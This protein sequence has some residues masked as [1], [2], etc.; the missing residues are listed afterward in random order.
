MRQYLPVS[1]IL[2][3]ACSAPGT[4]P[5]PVDGWSSL[6]VTGGDEAIGVD[7]DGPDTLACGDTGTLTVDVGRLPRDI[8]ILV[9]GSGSMSSVEYAEQIDAVEDLIDELVVGEDDDHVAL[10]GFSTSASLE[11]GLSHD[12]TDISTAL[13]D[14][15]PSSG[16]TNWA[17]ALEV[18]KT[19]LDDNGRSEA[20]DVVILITDGKPNE[21]S[22]RS[23]GP[24]LLATSA[25]NDLKDDGALV[26]GV[27]V[28]DDLELSDLALVASSPTSD[29]TSLVSTHADLGDGLDEA[30]DH[31]PAPEDVSVTATLG[32]DVAIDGSIDAGGDT[33]STSGDEVT[34]SVADGDAVGSSGHAL[35]FDFTTAGQGTVDVLTD[36]EVT[37]TDAGSDTT[38]TLDDYTLSAGVCGTGSV[39]DFDDASV[40][41]VGTVVS[42]P[43]TQGTGALAVTANW[44]TP[45]KS[46]PFDGSGLT[47]TSSLAVDVYLPASPPNPY[48]IG[49]L[50]MV[51]N[52]PS[53]GVYSAWVGRHAFTGKALGQYHTFTFTPSSTVRAALGSANDC[54]IQLNLNAPSGGSAFKFDDMRYV[55]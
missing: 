5:D 33:V 20:S 14:M 38:V 8:V 47:T 48:W 21:P 27:G 1:F 23:S 3:F 50:A 49:D 36:I 26:L 28:G 6:K 12:D 9:D 16:Q 51:V 37:Y 40:W 42:S 13:T 31:I 22:G 35:T 34:W 29:T 24:V 18:A 54:T 11:L 7:V 41:S 45:I 19:E 53:D 55:P 15:T 52:C 10:V 30:A 43:I 44:W 2:A 46:D 32:G 4:A 39:F 17:G 25:A